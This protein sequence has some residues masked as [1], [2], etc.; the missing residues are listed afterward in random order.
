MAMGRT[1]EQQLGPSCMRYSHKQA[2]VLRHECTAPDTLEITLRPSPNQRGWTTWCRTEPVPT[3][4]FL[5]TS[6][7]PAHLERQGQSRCLRAS[8]AGCGDCDSSKHAR[9]SVGGGGHARPASMQPFGDLG[10][11]RLRHQ[12]RIQAHLMDR[13]GESDR[14]YCRKAAACGQP[15]CMYARVGRGW[16]GTE[17]DNDGDATPTSR[18][19]C[20]QRPAQH[21]PRADSGSRTDT[22]RYRWPFLHHGKLSIAHGFC[23]RAT[24]ETAASATCSSVTASIGSGR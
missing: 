5:F 21:G 11:D 22:E 12:A 16:H 4:P 3:K 20:M 1:V 8:V 7:W 15:V 17:A 2:Q 14:M 19:G 10:V 13:D 6:T 23:G 24:S 18:Q 9:R